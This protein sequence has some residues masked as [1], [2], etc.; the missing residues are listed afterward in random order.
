MRRRRGRGMERWMDGRERDVFYITIAFLEDSFCRGKRRSEN[1]ERERE[2][3]GREKRKEKKNRRAK[4]VWS[5]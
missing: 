3:E 4:S 5:G 2:R 1:G